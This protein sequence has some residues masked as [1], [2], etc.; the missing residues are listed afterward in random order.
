MNDLVNDTVEKSSTYWGN[1]FALIAQKYKVELTEI[2]GYDWIFQMTG[3]PEMNNLVMEVKNLIK[4]DTNLEIHLE[5]DRKDGIPIMFEIKGL[6]NS[7]DFYGG[8]KVLAASDKDF[9]K[10]KPKAMPSFKYSTEKE[11]L[12]SQKKELM[13]LAE[14]VACALENQKDEEFSGLTDEEKDLIRLFRLQKKYGDNFEKMPLKLNTK[15]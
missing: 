8:A 13:S 14:Q 7:S 3:S 2:G 5:R 11:A 15:N 1:A 12:E 6:R 9:W 4:N 10:N